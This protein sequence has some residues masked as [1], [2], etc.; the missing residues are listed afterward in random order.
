[1][2][3]IFSCANAVISP[4]NKSQTKVFWNE[5]YLFLLLD[6]VSGKEVNRKALIQEMRFAV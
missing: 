4:Q 6:H 3:F 2:R 5:I 1:M